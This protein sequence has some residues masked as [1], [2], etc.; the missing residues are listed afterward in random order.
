MDKQD[1][2]MLADRLFF[3]VYG[4]GLPAFFSAAASHGVRLRQIRIEQN[5]AHAEIW[6]RDWP[7]V[8]SI[9]QK[10]G[11]QVELVRRIGPGAA[12]NMLM[13][14]TGI[15]VGMLLFSVLLSIFSDYIWKIEYDALEPA[16]QERAAAVLRE[17]GVY[18]GAR[19]DADTLKLAQD[20][21]MNGSDEY[22]WVSLN[23][24]GGCLVLESTA[25]QKQSVRQQTEDLS[26]YAKADACVLTVET[27]S[28]FSLVKPGQTVAEGQLLVRDYRLDRSEQPVAQSASG[29]ILGRVTKKYQTIQPLQTTQTCL[30]GVFS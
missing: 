19:A 18:E 27:E 6:G 9:A 5:G 2:F 28:G 24:T 4:S 14:R 20:C 30:T 23:F 3:S 17:C 13:R 21:L 1:L 10:G 25:A 8:R 7:A 26:L 15:P 29:H 12:V 22:G 16:E 11:W